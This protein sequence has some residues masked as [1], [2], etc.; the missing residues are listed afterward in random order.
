M[1]YKRVDFKELWLTSK[2]YCNTN[3]NKL[4][5]N[6][7]KPSYIVSSMCGYEVIDDDVMVT[8]IQSHGVCPSSN[9]YFGK[10][11]RFFFR[12]VRY[13]RLSFIKF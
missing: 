8:V 3:I 4:R 11:C 1:L 10:F 6:E 5:Q 12:R 7:G 9:L 2:N 13:E